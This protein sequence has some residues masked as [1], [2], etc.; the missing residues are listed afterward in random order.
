MWCQLDMLCCCTSVLLDSERLRQEDCKFKVNLGNL[1]RSCLKVKHSK[2]TGDVAECKHWV[3]DAFSHK[4]T[5]INM[6]MF[7]VYKVLHMHNR[8]L[9][10][11]QE[12]DERGMEGREKE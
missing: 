11:D 7:Y 12:I 2:W 5:Y 9:S 1:L 4:Y 8:K 10:I 6:H 3:H